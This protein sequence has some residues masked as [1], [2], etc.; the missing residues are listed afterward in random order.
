MGKDRAV[1]AESPSR[2]YQDV[3]FPLERR[4]DNQL[5][6]DEIDLFELLLVIWKGRF[7]IAFVAGFC[8]ILGMAYAYTAT[9]WFETGFK[10]SLVEESALFE[11][12]NSELV[13]MSPDTALQTIRRKLLS[14]EN[15]N[16]FYNKEPDAQNFLP[17][18]EGVE[19]DRYS[20]AVFKN[21]ISEVEIK[22]KKEELA[23]PKTSFQF[24]FSYP[25]AVEGDK[26]LLAYLAWTEQVIKLELVSSFESARDNE[27]LLNQRNMQKALNEYVKDAEITEARALEDTKF[28]R[29]VLQDQLEA[30][31]SQLIKK[32]QQ[33]I[34]VLSENISIAKRLGFKK[35]TTPANEKE[36]KSVAQASASGVEIVNSEGDGLD[37]LPLYYRGYESLEAEKAE[38]QNRTKDNFPSTALADIEHKIALLENDRELERINTRQ[39]PQAFIKNYVAL[40]KRNTHLSALGLDES[41]VVLFKLDSKP[42]ASNAPVK[43]KKVLIVG[44]ALF[45]G[46]MMGVLLVLILSASKNRKVAL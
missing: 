14:A 6:H 22:V 26:L 35:P 33:R 29:L 40:E 21:Q 7:K 17:L 8:A 39:Q 18:P 25:E 11:V 44:L 37:K 31:K 27:L 12:N 4:S 45:V 19:A 16:Y 5:N 38:L 28:K 34:I 46:L 23:N 41:R 43:P 15:F 36:V 20:Y 30:L 1:I 24:K 2:E 10:I 32:N 9:Q 42:M 13:E 3:G